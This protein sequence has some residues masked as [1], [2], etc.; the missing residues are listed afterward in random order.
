MKKSKALENGLWEYASRRFA[1]N[2]LGKKEPYS[3]WEQ[4]NFIQWLATG[5]IKV[6]NENGWIDLKGKVGVLVT[7][8]AALHDGSSI[9]NPPATLA[10]SDYI[11]SSE[12]RVFIREK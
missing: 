7:G 12:A 10:G 1:M 2:L 8:T 5:E 6:P 9:V 4:N 11:F 3:Q